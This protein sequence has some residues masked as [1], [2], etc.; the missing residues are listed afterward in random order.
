M[1]A[2]SSLK[3]PFQSPL[4]NGGKKTRQLVWDRHER[5]ESTRI[6]LDLDISDPLNLGCEARVSVRS[7]IGR[8]VAGVV[9][10]SSA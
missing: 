9:V 10:S 2:L 8:V 5:L 7:E 1:D 4:G 3:I 6:S